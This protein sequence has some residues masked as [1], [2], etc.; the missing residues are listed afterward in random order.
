MVLTLIGVKQHEKYIKT[1]DLLTRMKDDGLLPALTGSFSE[2]AIA[3]ACGQVETLQLQER[4][5]IRKTKRIQEELIRV[6]NFAALYGVLCRQEIGDEEIASVLESADGYGEKL[7]AYPQEQV[8]AVMKLELLPSLRFE[9]LKYYFPFVMY[10][11]EEQVILDNLQTFP[12]AEWKGLSMLTEHQRDMIRQPFL[13]SYLFCWHQNERKA[14]E[15][16]EQNR[17][18]QRVCILLYRYGVRLFLSVERLKD[19]RWMKMTDVGKFR[20]LLAVFEYDTEDLSAFFDLWL[21]N[22]AGQYDLNWFISQPHPLSKERRE[23]IFMQPT[24][25]SEC[26]VCRTGSI[27]ILMLSGNS[28]FQFSFMR[29]SIE[30]SIFWN[31][32]I[33]T[34][35]CSC[36][37]GDTLYCLSR[38]F[39]STVTSI[40]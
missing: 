8:L 27:W 28:S 24:E 17:P 22:H 35:K 29:W 14:L 7:T 4:L 12:I 23:E 16:L 40:P 38:A 39:V 9:Y 33:R 30:K 20:R 34:V 18:L 13:G 6:P 25:L 31:W 26:S 1:S 37:W 36:P 3:Q 19:L 32:W 10:E 2:D 15:L 11:E 5:H 21:D